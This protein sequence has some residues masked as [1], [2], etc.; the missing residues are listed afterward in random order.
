MTKTIKVHVLD[1]KGEFIQTAHAAN[2]NV[3]ETLFC[4]L[5]R[6]IDYHDL[7]IVQSVAISVD[8][9]VIASA[10]PIRGI[11]GMRQYL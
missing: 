4:D 9:I 1:Y 2:W 10:R 5:L 8:G 6:T 7:Y 3:A 11:V